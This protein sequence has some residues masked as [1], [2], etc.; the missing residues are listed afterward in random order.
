MSKHT[1]RS[2]IK[3]VGIGFTSLSLFTL[4]VNAGIKRPNILFIMADDHA[5][6]AI[7]AYGSTLIKTPNIDRL[8]TEGMRFTNCF[9][10]NSL[11]APSRAALITG[12]YSHHNG[13]MRNGD[14]FDGSQLT[15]PKLLQRSGYETAL[16]GKWHLKS[17]PAGFDY[18]SVIPGQG[19]FF[20]PSF[21]DSGKPWEEPKVVNGYL[22][23]IIT[24]KA[25]AWLEQRDSSK[26]FCMMVHHKA[27]HMPHLYPKKYETLYADE[28]LPLPDNFDANYK[29][30]GTTL[31]ESQARWSKLDHA[32]SYEF[33]EE[34]P[35]GLKRGTKEF[36]EWSYQ[37]FF[38][39]YLRLVASLDDNVGRLLEYLD[40][41]GLGKN[42]LVV[43]TSDNGFF[44]GEFGLY[45]KM[46]MYEESLRLPLM[47][48]HPDT[49]KP[50]SVNDELVSILDFAPTFLDYAQ[51]KAPK[52]LQGHSFR[53]IL[54]GKAPS[55]WRKAHYYHYYGQYDV[56]AHYGVRTL[57]H[58]LIHY[59]EK[60]NWELFDMANDPQELRKIYNQPEQSKVV[61]N[62]KT[63]LK[64]M[65]KKYE[66]AV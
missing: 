53:S 60:D 45:N 61:E 55:D 31:A 24:D 37:C 16:I 14:T 26:P 43:Y 17:Q 57:E 28:D 54:E 20:D 21:K 1:R 8:A 52:E 2:F 5:S 58:K 46:W 9:N 64:D 40:K 59:Y 4:K 65:R 47:V 3:N 38:K 51:A 56:P 25:A 49:I 13:F 10:V 11:C 33:S 41:K 29:E 66:D 50:E 15:F 39:G 30:R 34:I 23:D 7:S 19:E 42:T 35:K 36:K 32:H 6:H 18:Y 12:K 27:P 63:M 22:T 62:M 44:S 48:R